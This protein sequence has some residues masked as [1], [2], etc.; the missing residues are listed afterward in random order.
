MKP[1]ITVEFTRGLL[2]SYVAYHLYALFAGLSLG[3]AI[4]D[5]LRWIAVVSIGVVIVAYGA[6]GYALLFTP[7]GYARFVTVFLAVILFIHLF[8][9]IFWNQYRPAGLPS[10]FNLALI[11]QLIFGALFVGLAYV[12]QRF[13]KSRLQTA[14]ERDGG[15]GGKSG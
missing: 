13:L 5:R 10:P 11:S 14:S 2:F 7:K 4:P 12:H 15:S 1:H 3:L 8:G 6:I 9:V